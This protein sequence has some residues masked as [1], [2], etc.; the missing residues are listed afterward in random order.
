MTETDNKPTRNRQFTLRWKIE[1]EGEVYQY[2]SKYVY[3]GDTQDKTLT[4][5]QYREKCIR[6]G[7]RRG[8]TCLGEV[9]WSQLRLPITS[10]ANDIYKR[11]GTILGSR[12]QILCVY[13]VE[14]DKVER[15]VKNDDY[16]G[17]VLE[18]EG[19]GHEFLNE[20]ADEESL[21]LHKDF[22]R[23]IE[24]LRRLHKK[25]PEEASLR[26]P[27]ILSALQ[28]E[29]RELFVSPEA[30]ATYRKTGKAPIPVPT[31]EEMDAIRV[32][33]SVAE[34]DDE[35]Q[36]R[37][38]PAYFTM[39]ATPGEIVTLE[40]SKVDNIN[41]GQT[42]AELCVI[43]NTRKSAEKK[44]A[45]AIT[46]GMKYDWVEVERVARE[47][48]GSNLR[49]K[50]EGM[51]QELLN[52]LVTEGAMEQLNQPHYG[53]GWFPEAHIVDLTAEDAFMV[54]GQFGHYKLCDKEPID[55]GFIGL[56]QWQQVVNPPFTQVC[57]TCQDVAA[58][59][60][61]VNAD[62][63]KEVEL[64]YSAIHDEGASEEVAKYGPGE[65]AATG[66]FENYSNSILEKWVLVQLI[67]TPQKYK[68]HYHG[69]FCLALFD[70]GRR[71]GAGKP[72]IGYK[73]FEIGPEATPEGIQQ[74][75]EQGT[76]FRPG[77]SLWDNPTGCRAA[78]EIL[79]FWQFNVTGKPNL[80]DEWRESLLW[81]DQ[82]DD[83]VP[84]ELVCING[85]DWAITP[86]TDREEAIHRRVMD[87]TWYEANNFLYVPAS[88]FEGCEEWEQKEYHDA[89]GIDPERYPIVRVNDVLK[90]YTEDFGYYVG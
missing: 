31:V 4:F 40:A 57:K 20:V 60:E 15:W 47:Y 75:L 45:E 43:H 24:T 12:Q 38:T 2:E 64:G 51:T 62:T 30:M 58:G 85:H 17:F 59:R 42:L 22:K 68:F 83:P 32:E 82:H 89:L 27:G 53:E 54:V 1:D 28:P 36:V 5:F 72:T 61:E 26:P 16:S 66:Y 86:Q 73:L 80:K 48:I 76:D 29:E 14:T 52:G 23:R 84:R 69:N 87:T 70:F 19:K 88:V 65:E 55:S 25:D 67:G 7:I 90:R 8:E 63:R 33:V 71:D 9:R 56:D 44:L 49:V 10:L 35:G 79:T 41:L 78:A 21:S 77:V 37:P 11:V 81:T 13:N 74:T 18:Y 39:N 6:E 50:V 3:L 46:Q 34:R